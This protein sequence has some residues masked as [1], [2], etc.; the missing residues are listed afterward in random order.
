MEKIPVV[1]MQ[2][3]FQTD[4]NQGKAVLGFTELKKHIMA[5]MVLH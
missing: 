3:N 4:L 5:A 2:E 1:N